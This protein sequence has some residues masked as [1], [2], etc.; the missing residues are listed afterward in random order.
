MQQH[1]Y[2]HARHYSTLSAVCYT[3]I[4]DGATSASMSDCSMSWFYVRPEIFPLS[5]EELL[6]FPNLS[7]TY[8]QLQRNRIKWIME[9]GCARR[10]SIR[11]KIGII[12]SDAH[13]VHGTN[14]DTLSSRHST[15]AVWHFSLTHRIANCW[16]TPYANGCTPT[17]CLDRISLFMMIITRQSWESYWL[18]NKTTSAGVSNF[19]GD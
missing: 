4:Q 2:V 8:Y 13:I 1:H 7:M 5:T 14:G 10:V 11:Q 16:K 6:H 19:T 9:Q 18:D 15:R 12:S 3:W 17:Y